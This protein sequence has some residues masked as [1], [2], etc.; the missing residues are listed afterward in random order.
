MTSAYSQALLIS[1]KRARESATSSTK[2][3][4]S[5]SSSNSRSY[6]RSGQQQTQQRGGYYG[7]SLWSAD[8]RRT[9]G[10]STHVWSVC[11]L[12][13]PSADVVSPTTST[14]STGDLEFFDAHADKSVHRSAG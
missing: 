13:A 7:G 9:Y 8:L 1:A 14:S 12:L 4:S 11:E 10:C 2:P 5:S 6:N 3:G